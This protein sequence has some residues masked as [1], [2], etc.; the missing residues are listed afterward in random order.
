VDATLE[1]LRVA[2]CVA[3]EDDFLV[4]PTILGYVSSYYYLDYRTVGLIRSTLQETP[5]ATHEAL[6][7][8][9]V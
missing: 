5:D 1:D 4:R 6:V 9:C 7:R 2:G 3:V 8:A